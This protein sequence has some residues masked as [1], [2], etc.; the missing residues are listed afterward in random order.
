VD[1]LDGERFRCVCNGFGYSQGPE[2]GSCVVRPNACV[3]HPCGENIV[4]GNSCI[5]LRDGTHV[6]VCEHKRWRLA[7]AGGKQTC[8][9]PANLCLDTLDYCHIDAGNECVDKHDGSFFCRCSAEGWTSPFNSQICVAPVTVMPTPAPVPDA[10]VGDDPC[11]HLG[12]PGNTCVDLRPSSRIYACECNTLRGWTPNEDASHCAA[13]VNQ[14]VHLDDV[15]NKTGDYRN[16][17][18]DLKDGTY[19]CH[20]DGVAWTATVDGQTC[21]PPIN[22]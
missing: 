4:S 13:P 16:R 14:C 18:E 5:D 2:D 11:S 8:V 6:C 9:A 10:C 12:N 17:C 20:C 21:S 19:R 7:M 3:N 15:C 22:M 1:R